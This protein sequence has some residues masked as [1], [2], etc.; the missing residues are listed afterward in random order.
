VRGFIPKAQFKEAAE[1]Y[2]MFK[3]A[4]SKLAI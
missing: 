1:A 4:F 2:E 3:E